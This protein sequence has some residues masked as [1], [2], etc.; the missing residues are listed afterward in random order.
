MLN[1]SKLDPVLNQRSHLSGHVD[2]TV[3][4]PLKQQA[5]WTSTKVQTLRNALNRQI[6][7]R[8]CQLSKTKVHLNLTRT[9]ELILVTKPRQRNSQTHHVPPTSEHCLNESTLTIPTRIPIVASNW[10]PAHRRIDRI[11]LKLQDSMNQE[12]QKI[13]KRKRIVA[14]YSTEGGQMTD[15]IVP[16]DQFGLI[17]LA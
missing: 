6:R 17:Q 2:S 9:G 14:S 8:K 7:R 5:R 10:K 15:Q 13:E 12:R 4:Q 16:K 3:S 11:D 1:A